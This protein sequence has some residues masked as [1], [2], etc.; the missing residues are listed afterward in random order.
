MRNPNSEA[1]RWM[2]TE[3]LDVPHNDTT[4]MP[5]S[6]VTSIVRIQLLALS[7]ILADLHVERVQGNRTR[8]NQLGDGSELVSSFVNGRG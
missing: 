4:S 2:L 1:V 8:L 5:T 7:S 3:A 6:T